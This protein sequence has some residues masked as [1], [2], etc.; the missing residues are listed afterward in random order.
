MSDSIE[1]FSSRVD[2]YA[3][4]R[5]RYPELLL[6]LLS[7]KCELTPE[8]TVADVGSGTGLL[9]K[10]FL[11]N[12]NRVFAIEPNSGMRRIAE[13]ACQSFPNFISVDARA[14]ATTL[15]NRSVDLVT[16]AQAFHWFDQVRARQE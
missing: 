9:T 15:E 5:P 8:T 16:A 11:P 13:A 2:N 1:R 3:K 4:Y 7:A 12:G 14:E 6:D 10:L